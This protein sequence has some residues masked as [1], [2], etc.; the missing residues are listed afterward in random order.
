MS[1][2]RAGD[3]EAVCADL[4]HARGHGTIQDD[5]VPR[6]DGGGMVDVLLKQAKRDEAIINEIAV[7][8]R[9]GDK[10]KVFELAKEL[11]GNER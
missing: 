11:V 4:G 6:D 5:G 1:D 9:N 8:V 7:A 10:D 2:K 3:G